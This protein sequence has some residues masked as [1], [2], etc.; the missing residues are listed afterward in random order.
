MN[1]PTRDFS[2][3]LAEFKGGDTDA[4]ARLIALIYDDL[5]RLAGAQLSGANRGRDRTMSATVLVHECYLRIRE[6]VSGRVESKQHFLNLAAR[7]MRQVLCDYARERLADKRGAGAAHTGLEKV[8]AQ[9]EAEASDMVELDDLLA[10]LELEHPK[11]ARVFEC[12]YFAGLS[13][14]ETAD[15]LGVSLRTAQRDWNQA[16]SWLS[17]RMK[18]H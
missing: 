12:R 15:A 5:R 11:A 14:Q 17:E 18:G 16:R 7:I 4:S 6:S 9:L 10:K 2:R 13:E 1:A 8:D 3:I